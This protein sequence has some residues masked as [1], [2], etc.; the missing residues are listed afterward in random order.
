MVWNGS[1]SVPVSV[2]RFTSSLSRTSQ[3][4]C[5]LLLLGSKT[6]L[7]CWVISGGARAVM[8]QVI[9]VPRKL[10]RF[11]WK[12]VTCS[13]S[14]KLRLWLS[15]LAVSF[16]TR[17]HVSPTMTLRLPEYCDAIQSVLG[18]SCAGASVRRKTSNAGLP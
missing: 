4:F 12:P 13:C 14:F 2:L 1:F 17:A 8:S 7:K 5:S 18:S 3:R 9:L 15:S 6:A 10:F 11:L 16:P